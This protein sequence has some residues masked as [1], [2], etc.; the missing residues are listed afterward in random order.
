MEIIQAQLKHL[1]L[2]APLFDAYRIFYKQPSDL[3]GAT[4]FLKS[5]FELNDSIL[6]LA[7][8]GDDGIG[9]TQLYP[10]YSSVTMEPFYILNDLYVKPEA[11]RIGIGSQLLLAAQ[12]FALETN[13]KGLELATAKDNP[14]QRLYEK[15]GWTKDEEFFR[16][17]WRVGS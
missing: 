2:L 1:E 7:F 10:T 5:R 9:F 14:A 15:L 8:E 11:R 13:Q 17:F 16:Y 4:A 3:L 12:Q 6:F